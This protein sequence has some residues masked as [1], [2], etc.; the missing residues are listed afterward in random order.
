MLQPRSKGEFI[1]I[2]LDESGSETW[3]LIDGTTNVQ[4]ISEKLKERF[5]EK[6]NFLDDTEIRVTRFLTFLYAQRYITFREI[7]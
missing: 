4:A 6:I 5:S 1:H 2:K 7:Q 3:L